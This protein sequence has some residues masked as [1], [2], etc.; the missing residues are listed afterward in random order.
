MLKKKKSQIKRT[1]GMAQDADPEL[2]PWYPKKKKEI[3]VL[4][5]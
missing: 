3:L 5:P 4:Q 2:K 1:G